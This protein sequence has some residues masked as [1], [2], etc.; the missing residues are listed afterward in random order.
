MRYLLDTNVISELVVDQ[1]NEPV[2]Q[3]L[4]QLDPAGIY[5]SV[6]TF[7]ELR[8]EFLKL[9]PPRTELGLS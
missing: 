6:I 9:F 8:K 1:P 2:G 3:W 4:D 7:S 5:L